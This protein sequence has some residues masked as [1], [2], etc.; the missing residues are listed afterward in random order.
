MVF[1]KHKTVIFVHGCFFH[2]HK[3][4]YGQVV[5]TTNSEFWQKKRTRTK[6]RDQEKKIQLEHLGW[7]VLEY[8]ECETRNLEGLG[9]KIQRDFTC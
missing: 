4:K 5:P 1:P 9:Q 8:W 2:M 3:C 6:E 7:R